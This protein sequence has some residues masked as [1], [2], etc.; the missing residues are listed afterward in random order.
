M[1]FVEGRPATNAQIAH[2]NG[3]L[4]GSARYDPAMTDRHRAAFDNLVLLCKPHHDL[5]DRISA[6]DY[7]AET[8]RGWKTG[9]EGSGPSPLADLHGLTEERLADMLE[10]AMRHH[11]P[12]R[13]VTA[14]TLA[15]IVV[16]NGIVTGPFG[17][18][19]TIPDLNPHLAD[20]PRVVVAKI[21][22][23]GGLD[24][25]I[26]DVSIY[27]GIGEAGV[28]MKLA[29]RNDFPEYNP[30]LPKLLRVGE[31]CTWLTRLSTFGLI[32]SSAR[33][34][35]GLELVDFRV[36]VVLGSGEAVSSPRSLASELDGVR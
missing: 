18:W 28:E 27:Y 36:E 10:A 33:T 34:H 5:V 25:S 7:P 29:G 2:I 3:A 4:P 13:V 26:D 32:A 24:A 30:A 31:S 14:E 21:R 35:T 11:Q 6:A 12:Q 9:R 19:S 22:N 8:L 17:T 20:V 15:G 16:G 1:V 23:M